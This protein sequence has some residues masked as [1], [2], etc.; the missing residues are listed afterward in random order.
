MYAL[1]IG[2][3]LEVLKTG[4]AVGRDDFYI[5]VHSLIKPQISEV[6]F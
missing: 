1:S 6:L 5:S 4:L 3:L 2:I